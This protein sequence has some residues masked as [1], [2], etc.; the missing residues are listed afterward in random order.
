MTSGPRCSS[1][2]FLWPKQFPDAVRTSLGPQGIDKTIQDGQ[3]DVTIGNDGAII[4]KQMQVL[5]PA[6]IILVELSKAQDLE[7][8]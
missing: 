4:L 2:T 7:A 3:G 6:I 5:D 1:A 8:G